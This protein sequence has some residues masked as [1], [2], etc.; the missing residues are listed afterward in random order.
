M[1]DINP[2][3]AFIFFKNNKSAKFI[4]YL[5]ADIFFIKSIPI[6]REFLKSKKSIF[7]TEHGFHPNHDIS[8]ISGRFCVQ[9][10]I[11]KNDVHCEKILK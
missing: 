8:D 6:I 7:L 1:L 4:T 9:Y 3:F 2:I 11:Y 10:M 5:D